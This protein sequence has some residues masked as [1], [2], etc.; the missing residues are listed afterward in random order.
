MGS[1]TV[2][3]GI[4]NSRNSGTTPRKKYESSPPT[5]PQCSFFHRYCTANCLALRH[6]M[7]LVIVYL[8]CES[9]HIQAAL[10]SWQCF[11]LLLV[12]LTNFA[13]PLHCRSASVWP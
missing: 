8:L 5:S 1:D 3:A 4:G 12:L 2:V 10:H 9:G 6:S 13:A 11:H 7:L